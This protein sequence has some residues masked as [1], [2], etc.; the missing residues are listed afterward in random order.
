MDKAVMSLLKN[1]KRLGLM[2]E[3]RDNGLREYIIEDDNFYLLYH[4]HTQLNQRH[5]IRCIKK[6]NGFKVYAEATNNTVKT[7]Y[8]YVVDM[9]TKEVFFNAWD[10]ATMGSMLPII[11]REIERVTV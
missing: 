7:V 9:N 6:M 11:E 5:K 8:Y 3:F 1:S 2:K 10:T 4:S